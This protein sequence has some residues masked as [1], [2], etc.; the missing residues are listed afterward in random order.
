M[1]SAPTSTSTLPFTDLGV[2]ASLADLLGREG[3]TDPFPIQT[4]TLPDSLCGP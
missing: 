3:I 2:P 4:A 1:S